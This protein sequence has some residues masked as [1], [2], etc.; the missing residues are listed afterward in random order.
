MARIE[1]KLRW[2]WSPEQI[3]GWLRVQGQ[4]A[5]SHETIYRHVWRDKAIGGALWRHLRG[6]RK[7]RRKRYGAYDSRGRLA[8]KRMIEQRPAI[9]EERRRIG[10]WEVDTIHGL[11]RACLV[12]ATERKSGLVRIG[13]IPRA[14]KEH[15]AEKLLELLLGE[16]HPVRTITSDNG[17]EFHS[18]ED[19][20]SGLKTKM[21]F[22]TPHH[23]WERGSNENCNGLIRQYFPKRSN[24]SRVTQKECDEVAQALNSRPRLRHKFS[25]PNDIYYKGLSVALQM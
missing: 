17:T 18:Y 14:T 5:M 19:I 12:T 11:G 20:E 15:T 22:A 7:R 21:Y 10:D 23:A 1:E 16:A 25:T 24:L 6:A 13:P 2:N 4:P 3:V 8:G 9:V